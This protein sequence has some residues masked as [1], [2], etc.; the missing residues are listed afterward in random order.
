MAESYGPVRVAEN[1]GDEG[2]LAG[3]D[4]E[5]QS[6]QGLAELDGVFAEDEPS[7]RF[8]ADDLQG[9]QGYGQAGRG[10][11]RGKDEAPG[12]VHEVVDEDPLPRHET[13]FAGQGLAQGAHLDIDGC[14][15]AEQLHRAASM[16]P[17]NPCGMGVV[18]HDRQA[19]TPGHRHDLR[20]GAMSPSTL[21]RP[22]VTTRPG[23]PGQP[24]TFRSR[25]RHRSVHIRS[26]RRRS[27]GNRR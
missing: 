25:S 18:H 1:D 2:R 21:N 8:P 4:P 27:G 12:R 10:H 15:E 16:G 19:V 26:P 9:L 11:G 7:L 3:Q 23:R 20:Q 22:S 6:P 24:L 13:A 5:A 17:Q 14:L